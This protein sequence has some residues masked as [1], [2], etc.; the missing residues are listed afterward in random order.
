MANKK[1]VEHILNGKGV[2]ASSDIKKALNEKL[3]GAIE[4]ERI[5]TAQTVY[6]MRKGRIVSEETRRRMSVAAKKNDQSHL[7]TPESL[8]KKAKAL[9]GK[10]RTEETKR[11]MSNSIR[12][13][14]KGKPWS[15]AR[16]ACLKK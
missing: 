1:L 15:D 13:A 10:K 9:T 12:E 14:M 5:K 3:K 4:E 2:E 7:Y 6:E 16:R 8:L 11:K